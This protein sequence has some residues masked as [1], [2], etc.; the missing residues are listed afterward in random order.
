MLAFVLIF[1]LLFFLT[2]SFIS[3]KNNKNL[4][5]INIHHIYYYI[6]NLDINKIVDLYKSRSI[7]EENCLFTKIINKNCI[8]TKT[9]LYLLSKN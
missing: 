3:L 7:L 8:Y 5:L 4:L 1:F 2:I 9:Q 6:K